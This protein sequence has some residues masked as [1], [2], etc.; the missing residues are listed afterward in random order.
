MVWSHMCGSWTQL[1]H[2]PCW[3]PRGLSLRL[4]LP[5]SMAAARCS[6]L[7]STAAQGSKREYSPRLGVSA[8]CALLG[9]VSSQQKFE[10][11]DVRARGMS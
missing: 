8:E 6:D 3:L 2:Q 7:L 5:H 4:G 9:S 11:M 1:G 10:A